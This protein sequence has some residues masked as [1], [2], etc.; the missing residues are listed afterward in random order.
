MNNFKSRFHEYLKQVENYAKT[1]TYVFSLFNYTFKQDFW[2]P[3]YRYS[4]TF[5]SFCCFKTPYIHIYDFL[6]F[7]QKLSPSVV[8]KLESIQCFKAIRYCFSKI[9]FNKNINNF[10]LGEAPKNDPNLKV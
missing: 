7:H 3:I 9:F 5:I 1:E 2:H 6:E 10:V 8:R 4:V